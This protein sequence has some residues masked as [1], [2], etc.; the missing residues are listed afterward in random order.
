MLTVCIAWK[1]YPFALGLALGFFGLLRPQEV[2]NVRVKHL[3]LRPCVAELIL[4]ANCW[5][6]G[7]RSSGKGGTLCYATWAC[8]Q[9]SNKESHRPH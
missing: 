2:L 3:L 8:H 4:R 6:E 1:W 9:M 7:R 5:M